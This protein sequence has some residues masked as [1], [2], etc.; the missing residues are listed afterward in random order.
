M[1]RRLLTL[2]TALLI[3][4][5]WAAVGYAQEDKFAFF[6]MQKFMGNSEKAK[7]QQKKLTDLV[8][9]QKKKLDGLKKEIMAL[10]QEAENL[11]PMMKPEKQKQ[12]MMD[13]EKKKIEYSMAEKEAQSAVQAAEQKLMGEMQA[14]ITDKI[15]KIRADRNLAFVFN[16][17]ALVSADDTLDITAEVIK[18][19]DGD[20]APPKAKAPAPKPV[21]P[22]P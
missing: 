8:D 22:K 12:L 14:E 1:V 10:N 11:G 19:Y 20:T 16:S 21:K 2:G 15:R 4:V 7:G 6:D 5:A 9:V 3:A 18:A 17:V 13:M